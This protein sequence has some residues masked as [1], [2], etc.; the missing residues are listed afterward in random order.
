MSS[1]IETLIG[2]KL[3]TIK[4]GDQ[5]TDESTEEILASEP[6]PDDDSYADMDDIGSGESDTPGG[7]KFKT[8]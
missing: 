5:T 1:L 3:Q 2:R 6:L 4:T 8:K 7:Y